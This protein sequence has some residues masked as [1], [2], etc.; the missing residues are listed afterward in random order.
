MSMKRFRTPLVALSLAALALGLACSDD[1]D[2]GAS[3]GIMGSGGGAGAGVAGAGGAGQGGEAQAGLGGQGAGGAGASGAAGSGGFRPDDDTTFRPE[4]RPF[5]AELLG[6]LTVKPGFAVSA[7][8]QGLGMARMM[9]V[10]ADGGVYVTRPMPGDVLLLRDDDG[11]GK[12][13]APVTAFAGG[14]EEFANLHGI[15]L[16]ADGK[17]VYL[18]TPTSLYVAGVGGDGT[19]GAPQA[20]ATDLPDGG[21]HGKRTLRAMPQTG[22]LLLS[23]GSSCDL[24]A[25]TN[26]EHA[27]LLLI[28]PAKGPQTKADR[29]IFAKGLRNTIGFDWYPGT[30]DELWGMDHG[31]DHHGNALPP[32]ELNRLTSG[33]NYG[34]PYVYSS[35]PGARDIDPIM[36]DPPG[37]TKEQ[38]APSTQ[39]AQLTY[40]AHSAPIEFRF[41]TGAQFP[42]EYKNDAFVTLHG[43]W[44]RYP[45]V[46]Y[47]VVRVLFDDATRQP[48]G[49]EDLVSGWLVEGGRAY[50]GRPAGLAQLPDGS[51]LV[52]DDAN[53][54]VY[55]IAYPGPLARAPAP[56]LGRAC[57]G[58]PR[59]GASGRAA[60][61][62]TLPAVRALLLDGT[63][64]PRLVTDRS[65]PERRPG[66][67]LVGV[68]VAGVCDTDL[69]LLRGYMGFRGVPGHEFVGEVLACDDPARWRGRRVVADINAG[70]GACDDC[71]RARGHHCARRT[72]LGIAGRDGALA[73]RLV[74][75]ERCL[76][77]VPDAVSDD[78]AV[79][80]EPLAAALHV[81][82]ELDGA[83]AAGEPVVVL[84]DGKLGLLCALAL[85]GAGAKVLL[86]GHHP[87]KLAHAA[88][89]GAEVALESELGARGLDGAAA[90][91]VEATGSAQG[92]ALALRLT[93]PRGTVVLKTTVAGALHVDL[94]PVVIHEMRLVGSRCGDMGRAVGALARGEVDPTPL[95]AARYPLARAPEALARAGER[96]VLKVLVDVA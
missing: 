17:S 45:A 7:F 66:E 60:A 33:A 3:G 22:R 49:F 41:Y 18:A 56:P 62:A 89:A 59:S 52:S 36:D 79:F 14:G 69:Q 24:C 94:S 72:V 39:P 31:S 78:R 73:E 20:L 5:S 58:A 16:S 4:K 93:R 29:S 11:D 43:S 84:G 26:P 37:T 92:L 83:G 76:V 71:A 63:D 13:E 81:L 12:A 55:R 27:A 54:V 9:A 64:S 67:A 47:K 28:D 57:R 35:G 51:L 96:G 40:D 65:E 32:E 1:D 10:A 61:R 2:D 86:V 21:Q 6:G 50:F 85:R 8:A 30:T 90:L 23:I 38:W 68:R 91:V 88:G 82:D 80:A 42:A 34:W 77:E 95:I 53:G 46:G 70:C 25:E 15:E 75:P 19:L 48:V 87:A 74:V 44:N